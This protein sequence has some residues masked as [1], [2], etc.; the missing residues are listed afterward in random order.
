MS[1]QYV[2]DPLLSTLHTLPFSSF[3]NIHM[4]QKQAQSKCH[5]HPR[6]HRLGGQP[7][8]VW[9]SN[10]C[11]SFPTRP[12]SYKKQLFCQFLEK[13][14]IPLTRRSRPSPGPHGFNYCNAVIKNVWIASRTAPASLLFPLVFF[15]FFFS[16]YFSRQTLVN[17][18]GKV[19]ENPIGILIEIILHS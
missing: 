5:Q 1:I 6:P 12:L 17:H 10:P 9:L 19:P 4:K 16:V 18:F 3:H 7:K 2:C 11:P 14:S 13:C 15:C 8:S